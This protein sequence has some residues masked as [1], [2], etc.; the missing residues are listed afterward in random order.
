MIQKSYLSP[1]SGLHP[2]FGRGFLLRTDCKLRHSKL[3]GIKARRLG[4]QLVVRRKGNWTDE[5]GRIYLYPI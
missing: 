3:V 5:Y 1:V 4:F 2:A